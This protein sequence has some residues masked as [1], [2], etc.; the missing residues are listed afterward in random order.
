MIETWNWTEVSQAIGDHVFLKDI[1][2]MS[3]VNSFV[4]DLKLSSRV[5]FYI[6]K[7]C[8][9]I[10]YVYIYIYDKGENDWIKHRSTNLQIWLLRMSE[11]FAEKQ[12]YKVLW[13]PTY[14]L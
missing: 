4:Q 5:N 14:G 13:Y 11:K 9:T 6:N 8:T 7:Y 1:Y 3:N 2:A 12:T 10:I